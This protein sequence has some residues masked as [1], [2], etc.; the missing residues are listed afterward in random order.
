ME[1]SAIVGY[2]KV[3][4]YWSVPS[5]FFAVTSSGMQV[6]TVLPCTNPNFRAEAGQNMVCLRY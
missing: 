4:T 2:H 3:T 6:R 5:C 1:L